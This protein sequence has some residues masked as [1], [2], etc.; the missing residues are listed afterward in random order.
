MFRG[1]SP[2]VKP[3]TN[4]YHQVNC[5][6]QYWQLRLGDIIA[7]SNC[8]SSFPD[9]VLTST[10][11]HAIAR[12]ASKY[13]RLSNPRV[14]AVIKYSFVTILVFFPVEKR[15]RVSKERDTCRFPYVNG[16]APATRVIFPPRCA[17]RVKHRATKNK[18]LETCKWSQLPRILFEIL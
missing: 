9:L 11:L 14:S 6:E 2:P 5:A 10:I 17:T 15:G 1:F 3:R 7:Q 13:A 18:Q 12:V 4:Y 8:I 16:G